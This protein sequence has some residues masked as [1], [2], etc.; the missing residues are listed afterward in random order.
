MLSRVMERVHSIAQSS[1]ARIS[2]PAVAG[3][4]APP[5]IFSYNRSGCANSYPFIPVAA[6][7]PCTPASSRA[8]SQLLEDDLRGSAWRTLDSGVRQAWRHDRVGTAGPG[9]PRAMARTGHISARNISGCE[10][11]S[12]AAAETQPRLAMDFGPC[13]GWRARGSTA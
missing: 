7:A 1:V 5:D 9:A 2:A 12:A 6:S 3:G 13:R 11:D 4:I 10:T 8:A